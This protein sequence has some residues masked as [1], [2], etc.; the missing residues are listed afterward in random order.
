[1]SLYSSADCST[2]QVPN[3][4]TTSF[5]AVL[6]TLITALAAPAFAVGRQIAHNTPPYVAT[7]KNLG[8]ENPSKVMEVALWLQPHGPAEME[9]LARDLLAL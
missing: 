3:R 2:S 7:A 1:M 5:I 9:Q 6:A 4:R 8:T